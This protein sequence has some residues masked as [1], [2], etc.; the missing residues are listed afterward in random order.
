MDRA[1]SPEN[2]KGAGGRTSLTDLLA[3]LSNPNKARGSAGMITR[4]IR[5][6]Y[7]DAFS[8]DYGT[9]KEEAVKLS[10][11]EKPRLSRAGQRMLMQMAL[12]DLKL[13]EIADKADRLDNGRDT[14]R[15]GGIKAVRGADDDAI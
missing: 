1:E 9:L 15:I 10:K 2:D 11:S 12:H 5:A 13:M 7:L 4:A 6:G 8:I 14:E 3:D